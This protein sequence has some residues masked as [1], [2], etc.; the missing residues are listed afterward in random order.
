MD[1]NV[2]PQETYLIHRK[3]GVGSSEK[4]ELEGFATT[5]TMHREF[6]IALLCHFVVVR[7]LL[8]FFFW[9]GKASNAFTRI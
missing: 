9:G 1:V 8:R 2:L 7:S 4:T 6:L 3:D 5:A